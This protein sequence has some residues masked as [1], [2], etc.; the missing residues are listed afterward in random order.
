MNKEQKNKKHNHRQS[1]WLIAGGKIAWCYQCGA[2]KINHENA[3]RMW[4][5]PTGIG[6]I[7]P[8]MKDY[9]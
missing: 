3:P 4:N 5:K 2:W 7:N 9:I 8:A 6:G 1:L